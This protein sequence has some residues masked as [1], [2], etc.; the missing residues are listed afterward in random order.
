M[1]KRQWKDIMKIQRQVSTRQWITKS[2]KND[3]PEKTLQH[4]DCNMKKQ[5]DMI[6][7]LG[8]VRVRQSKSLKMFTILILTI[9]T[10]WLVKEVGP[11]LAFLSPYYTGNS[12][13]YVKIYMS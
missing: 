10:I 9:M 11:K 4:K 5:M 12:M 7:S 13:Q 2:H 6:K 3:P 8:Q 1:I